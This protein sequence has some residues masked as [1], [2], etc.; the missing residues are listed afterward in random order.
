MSDQGQEIQSQQSGFRMILKWSLIMLVLF[1]LLGIIQRVGSPVERHLDEHEYLHK[2]FLGDETHA[3]NAAGSDA[4]VATLFEPGTILYVI[5][6][7][8][9]RVQIRPFIRSQPDSVWINPEHAYLY[10]D[11][12]Y[13]NWMKQQDQRLYRELGSE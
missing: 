2:I 11:D 3:W 4:T 1:T 9:M 7:D 10:D 13:H 8:T 6:E 5:A 12:I